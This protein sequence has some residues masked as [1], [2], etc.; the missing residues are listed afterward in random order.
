MDTDLLCQLCHHPLV[1]PLETKCGHTFCTACLK[2]HLA[3]QALC[4]EDKQI[5]N[6]L[7]CC[8]ASII[9]KRLLDKLLIICPN[10]DG[11]DEIMPRSELEAH[12]LYWCRAIPSQSNNNINLGSTFQVSKGSSG[13]NKWDCGFEKSPNTTSTTVTIS[14]TNS[15]PPNDPSGSST[16]VNTCEDPIS[17][18]S[19]PHEMN[20]MKNNGNRSSGATST[21]HH[22]NTVRFDAM[23]QSRRKNYSVNEEHN[24]SNDSLS[25]II[26][27][28]STNSDL[29]ISFVG[30]ADTPLQCIV[31]QEIYLDGAV[32]KDGRLRPGDQIISINEIDL[33]QASHMQARH[34]FLQAQQQAG[35]NRL[36]VYRER[37]D[38]S[39][40]TEKEEILQFCLSKRA[41]KKLGI[42]LVG[43]KNKPGLYVLDL[44]KGS[45]ADLDGRLRKNDRI[46]NINGV[47]L[48]METQDTAARVIN[49][50]ENEVIIVVSRIIRPQ[51]PDLIRTAGP[52]IIMESFDPSCQANNFNVPPGVG[53]KSSGT[54]HPF[55]KVVVVEKN[56]GESLGMSVAGGVNSQRGDTPVYV[57]NL[58]V[59][60]VLAKTQ[61]VAKGDILL[62]V[63]D[64]ELLGLS[65]EKAVEALKS[66]GQKC[67]KVSVRLLQ[68]P[69]TSKN[70]GHN[71]LPSWV[72]WLQLPRYC[73][74][75][76]TITLKRDSATGSLGFSIVGGIDTSQQTSPGRFVLNNNAPG[77][78]ISNAFHQP[79]VVKSI[80]TGSVAH[81]NGR[82]K[83][84]DILLKVNN[85]SL[86]N[87]SHDDA[88][89]LFK[90]VQ[91][92]V[93][94]E[95]VSWP[96]TIV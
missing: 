62:A 32:A 68:G 8:P 82:L 21:N 5:I 87:V 96:G 65:H 95:V 66:A 45:E 6:Y 15:G 67:K 27:D 28:R 55:E 92:E 51:T 79:I 44:V 63:N 61:L 19:S 3:V 60:G 89:S 56:Y 22:K 43:Q 70:G 75:P 83:C 38:E 74:I 31:I 69:E 86:I 54:W 10:C 33:N 16:A 46:L 1:D 20:N 94:L 49:S 7:E 9:V 12:L 80:V 23:P 35:V 42:K 14:S 77:R 30:G 78:S 76:R 84:G 25:S 4:P 52:E 18:S 40:L 90:N 53:R 13:N 85:T 59:D 81:R 29:G 58:A 88:V 11:C 50:A 72:Y 26:I 91:D 64:A 24:I 71:F 36:M 2:S 41:D 73:E 93:N 48:R 57:T 34:A 37:A 47:D 17:V 39:V